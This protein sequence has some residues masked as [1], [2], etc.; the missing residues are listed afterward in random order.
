MLKL[1]FATCLTALAGAGWFGLQPAAADGVPAVANECGPAD[2][3]PAL[4]CEDLKGCDVTVEP[5]DRGT[6]LVTCESPDGEV[7]SAEVDCEDA[8][9]ACGPVAEACGTGADA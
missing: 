2:C 6:C 7:C 3:V 9:P 5:T 8:P 4:D 1:L